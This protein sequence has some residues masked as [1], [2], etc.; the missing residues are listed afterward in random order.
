MF[1]PQNFILRINTHEFRLSNVFLT[2]ET[3]SN[4]KVSIPIVWVCSWPFPAIIKISSSFKKLM[5]FFI[6]I[7]LPGI[8]IAFGLLFIIDFL[9]NDGSSDLGLSS[10]IIVKSEFLIVLCFMIKSC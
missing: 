7:S 10:V 4:G 1:C 6:A 2:T 5:A 8:S 3:S 9:I